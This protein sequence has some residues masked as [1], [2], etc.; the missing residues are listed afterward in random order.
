MIS[1]PSYARLTVVSALAT[2]AIFVAVAMSQNGWVFEYPLDDVYIHLAMAEGIAGGGYGVN[3]GE[4]ASA[5][6]SPLWPVLLVPFSGT[7][8]HRW[9]PLL[10][11]VVALAVA[12]ALFGRILG[13]AR[14]GRAGAFFA[15]L[16]PF[17][18]GMYTVAYAGMENMAHGAAS[19]AIVLG[20]WFYVETGRIGWL[21][22]LGVLLAPAFRLEGLALAMVAAGLVI[23]MGRVPAGLGLML[24]G[25]APV[26]G[27]AVF[28]MSQ[29][30][31][32]LPSSVMAKL[33]DTGGGGLA[34]KLAGNAASYGGRYLLGLAV[35]LALV[36]IAFWNSDRRRAYFGLGIA[37][38]G[39]A[40]L[41]FGAIGWLD[42]YENYAILSLAGALA[43]MV[44]DQSR[45]IR[46]GL[47][48]LVLLGGVLT[49]APYIPNNL[50]NMAAIHRQQAQMARFATEYLKAPVAVNDLGYVSWQNP[51]YVLDLWGLASKEALTTRLEATAPP[52]WGGALADAAGV[53]AA[54]I[55]EPWIG[56]ALG[57]DWVKLGELRTEGVPGAFLGGDI[58][59][60][61][62]RG[63]ADVEELNGLLTDWAA[64]LPEGAVFTFAEGAS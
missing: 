20:L 56:G 17:A 63:A 59:S 23:R 1:G 58:V 49:Y 42:R 12:A 40:H 37:L 9:M 18:L 57:P 33:S 54:M 30:L 31:G 51:S 41:A 28:L 43:L 10:L 61:F 8:F 29:G 55:Y 36:S 6:S 46:T 44:S 47:M 14:L 34:A 62:A 38:A 50:N 48:A 53:R 2:F 25:L 26:V 22:V 45:N 64:G 24:I 3:P 32:P 15:V 27:F 4:V 5:A 21:L 16:A 60:F 35:T 39:L 13:E 11:N 52:G 19:L 7:S